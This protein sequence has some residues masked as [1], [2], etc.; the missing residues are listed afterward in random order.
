M[1]L[2]NTLVFLFI[3]HSLYNYALSMLTIPKI[4]D[5][6]KKRKIKYAEIQELLHQENTSR[7]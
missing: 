3:M 1:L 7:L 2:V 4:N 6:S 5:L